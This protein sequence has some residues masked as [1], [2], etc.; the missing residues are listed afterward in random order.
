MIELESRSYG[1]KIFRPKPEVE[2]DPEAGLLIV[3]TPWGPRESA[4]RTIQ[5]MK[6][7]I[8][9]FREDADVTSPFPRL[10]CLSPALNNLRV[11]AMLAN[12]VLYREE[13]REEYVTGVELFAA[14][15]TQTEIAWLQ[16]GHPNVFLSRQNRGMMPLGCHMDLPLD[17]SRGDEI[18]P[19]LP[20]S[21]LGLDTTANFTLGSMIPQKGDRMVLISRSNVPP[22]IFSLTDEQRSLMNISRFLSA[23]GKDTA[24]WLGILKID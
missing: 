14:T 8:L 17:L 3:A 11:A 5:I 23:D 20:N 13:N 4:G 1:G 12:D 9:T 10:T 19:P 18:L 2:Y 7:Y 24:F 21:L 15:Y 6:E 22:A 16:L